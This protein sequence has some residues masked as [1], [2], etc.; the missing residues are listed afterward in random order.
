VVI[1]QSPYGSDLIHTSMVLK[2]FWTTTNRIPDAVTILQ[3]NYL[4]FQYFRYSE[5]DSFICLTTPHISFIGLWFIL[6][7]CQY[8]N[9]TASNRRSTDEF[10]KIWKEDDVARLRS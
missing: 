1:S 10:E 4:N 2:N 3:G 6:W 9:Y 8:L 5:Y 7:Y